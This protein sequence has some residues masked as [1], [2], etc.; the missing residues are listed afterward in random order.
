MRGSYEE[1]C[2]SSRSRRLHRMFRL[3][4]EF[5]LRLWDGE[6]GRAFLLDFLNSFFATY[7]RFDDGSARRSFHEER[8][9]DARIVKMELPSLKQRDRGRHRL[10]HIEVVT[11]EAGGAEFLVVVHMHKQLTA[12]QVAALA[13]AHRLA[14]HDVYAEDCS[15]TKV[16][17]WANGHEQ[18]FNQ[19]YPQQIHI[20][21]TAKNTDLNSDKRAYL[22]ASDFMLEQGLQQVTYMVEIKR[23]LENEPRLLNRFD[24]WIWFLCC[25]FV[26]APWGVLTAANPVFDDIKYWDNRLINERLAM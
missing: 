17:C 21:L 25:K 15:R 22:L 23:F 16:L 2:R 13:E 5:L 3:E 12:A 18:H 9:V 8:F 7:G 19:A 4:K 6:A 10:I 26:T 14:C 24:A 11:Q 1:L 20:V